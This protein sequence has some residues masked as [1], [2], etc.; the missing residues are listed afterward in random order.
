[1]NESRIYDQLGY[2]IPKTIYTE[3]GFE[4]HYY[5]IAKLKCSQT[6]VEYHQTFWTNENGRIN[7]WIQVKIE[8]NKRK[9]SGYIIKRKESNDVGKNYCQKTVENQKP[10]E[11][12]G[13]TNE[14]F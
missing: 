4:A 13:K 10:P 9:K 14:Q 7:N 12:E 1:M 5:K 3:N 11:P 8:P 6:Y 2:L